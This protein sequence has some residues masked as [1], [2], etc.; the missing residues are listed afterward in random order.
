MLVYSGSRESAERAIMRQG[1]MDAHA[2]LESVGEGG[3][4]IVDV[5][6]SV[7][8]EGKSLYPLS[9]LGDTS[10]VIDGL[11]MAKWI[12][13]KYTQRAFI[14]KE[15]KFYISNSSFYLPK[16]QGQNDI[17]AKSDEAAEE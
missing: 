12:T 9:G 1:M 2:L 16:H 8:T 14:H 6:Q 7:Y 5:N 15:Y 3:S 17:P 10:S 4:S 13:T 11:R